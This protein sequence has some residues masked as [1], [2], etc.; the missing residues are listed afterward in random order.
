MPQPAALCLPP[1]SDRR[2]KGPKLHISRQ[3]TS[4]HAICG[5]DLRHGQGAEHCR[6]C[7]RVAEKERAQ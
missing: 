3:D 4:G 1:S 5:K 6:T 7:V 2:A